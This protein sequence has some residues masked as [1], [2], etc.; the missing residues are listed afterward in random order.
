MNAI[1]TFVHVDRHTVTQSQAPTGQEAF[2]SVSTLA[3]QHETPTEVHL[4]VVHTEFVKRLGSVGFTRFAFRW[5]K[6][7]CKR[8]EIGKIYETL[9]YSALENK[10][11]GGGRSGNTIIACRR[12]RHCPRLR[13]RSLCTANAEH[14]EI[15]NLHR[16]TTSLNA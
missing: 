11:S 1:T 2:D 13:R 6:G 3:Y 16:L 12:R 14:M 10:Q 9:Y 7:L 8:G 15:C 4:Q 5:K